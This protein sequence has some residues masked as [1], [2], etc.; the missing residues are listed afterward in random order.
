MSTVGIIA[1][2]NPLHKGHEYLISEAKKLGRVV[3]IISGNFVQRGDTAIVSKEIRANSALISGVDL[4]AELPVL[5]S[6]STAQNFAIGGVS[7]AVGLG[8]DILI[9]GSEIGEIEPLLKIADILTSND[10]SQLLNNYLADGITFALARQKACED[11]G[12][13]K[14]ILNKPNNNLGIE[15]I[16]AAKKLG[17]S[18][19]FKTVKRKGACHDSSKIEEFVSSSLLR[20]KLLSGNKEFCKEYINKKI[21]ETLNDDS[22]SDIKRIESG[23]LSSL[24]MKTKEELAMLPDLS[25]GVE[26]KL[27]SAIKLATDINSLY[28]TIKVKRYPLARVRRLVLSAFLGFDNAYFLKPLPYIRVLGFNKNGESILKIATRN[29]EIPIITKVNEIKDT[30]V[31]KTESLATDIYNLSLKKPQKCGDE[32]TYKLITL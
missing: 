29:S 14:E 18:I 26:N 30:K 11:L 1:E 9:F 24:R 21:L 8:C 19:K 25:E 23:I 2:Y 22:L 17:V 3:S 13:E 15:Y 4:V 27:Y 10:F 7:A 6:M 12:A 20:E 16:V 32:Y 31:F 28:N 5:W